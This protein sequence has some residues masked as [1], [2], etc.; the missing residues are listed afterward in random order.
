MIAL[1]HDLAE[2]QSRRS[3][4]SPE[5][6]VDA[7]QVFA[8]FDVEI[9]KSE[10]RAT[11]D[12]LARAHDRG[13]LEQLRNLSESGMVAHLDPELVVDHLSW[14]AVTAAS[15]AALDAIE[16]GEK[17]VWLLSR[18][19]S[20]HAGPNY[21]MGF[22]L[23]NHLAVAATAA[24][25]SGYKRVLLLDFDAHHG[26]GSEDILLGRPGV[27]IVSLHQFPFF[28]GTGGESRSNSINFP[29]EAGHCSSK[30]E[31]KEVSRLIKLFNPELI[32]VEAGLDG[33]RDDWT[34]GLC[35]DDEEFFHWGRLLSEQKA[36]VVAEVG[37]GYSHESRISALSALM[38]GMT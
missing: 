17:I 24:I 18:P 11:I 31:R 4:D 23:I 1:E 26:N 36:K 7:K 34:S 22:C 25:A 3:I 20:H 19:G 28:P 12:E 27:A 5:R 8:R 14:P 6:I 38:E 9:I 13:Y 10:R 2:D 32:L 21:G 37:G 30:D 15:G 33:H 35:W 16:R 29:L